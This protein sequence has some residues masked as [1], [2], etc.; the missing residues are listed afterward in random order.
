M[1]VSVSISSIVIVCPK[2]SKLWLGFQ[3]TCTLLPH[4]V[5]LSYSSP[6]GLHHIR[7]EARDLA[8]N[9]G[10]AVYDFPAE[11]RLRRPRIL[12][13]GSFGKWMKRAC[14]FR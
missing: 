2:Y 13:A 6:P 11:L 12:I 8:E 4:L 3:Y 10:V 1:L 5:L 7:L 9:L 14:D